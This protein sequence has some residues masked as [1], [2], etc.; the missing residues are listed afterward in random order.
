[1]ELARMPEEKTKMVNFRLPLEMI[2]ALDEAAESAGLDR[3]DLL[4]RFVRRGIRE[5]RKQGPEILMKPEAI[6]E[7]KPQR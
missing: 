6:E 7:I 2:A 1:M 5:M 3:S 4:K